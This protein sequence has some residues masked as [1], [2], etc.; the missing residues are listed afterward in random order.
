MAILQTE[1]TPFDDTYMTY[2]QNTHR[3]T[4]TIAA[5][6]EE[7]DISLVEFAGSQANAESLL[8]EISSDVYK[9]IYKFNRHDEKH[10]RV[11]EYK[12]AKH[13]DAR[14]IIKDA[15]LDY[16]RA[17]IRSGYAIVKDLSPVNPELGIVMDF[18]KLPPI[19]PDAFDGLYAYGI[20]HR[21]EYNF[22]I[23]DD[24]YRSDY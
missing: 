1:I 5:V 9:A 24:A 7:F 15:M 21:G 20:L 8:R 19:A 13:P 12:L 10:R 22:T 3:Y 23:P 16:V 6:D 14:N 18:S 17:T 2:D 4:L 11:V